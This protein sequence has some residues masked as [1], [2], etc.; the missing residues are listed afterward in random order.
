MQH[1]CQIW[2]ASGTPLHAQVWQDTCRGTLEH[3]LVNGDAVWTLICPRRSGDWLARCVPP[4]APWGGGGAAANL[5]SARDAPILEAAA[6]LTALFGAH[7][8]RRSSFLAE[9]GVVALIELLE[10]RSHKVGHRPRLLWGALLPWCWHAS[11]DSCCMLLVWNFPTV[12]T[13]MRIGCCHA[14]LWALSPAF[15]VGG[16]PAQ[17]HAEHAHHTVCVTDA[18]VALAALE[19]ANAFVAN[20]ARLLEAACLLGLLPAVT[21]YAFAVWP[22]PLRAQ[23]A[24]FVHALC[25]VSDATAR[26]L[27]ACQ[28]GRPFCPDVHGNLAACHGSLQPQRRLAGFIPSSESLWIL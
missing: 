12:K 4:A 16:I 23:A 25:F 28:V 2:G 19:L 22:P 1:A 9:D 5:G 6:Q 3:C 20:D 8:S 13:D 11:A 24:R 14:Y 26:M 10:E 27:I 7:P 18:Q 15:A 17:E 21:R